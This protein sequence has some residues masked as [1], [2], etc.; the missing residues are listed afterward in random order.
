MEKTVK[1][2]SRPNGKKG[3]QEKRLP[4]RL[5]RDEDIPLLEARENLY[6]LAESLRQTL[7]TVRRI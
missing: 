5:R 4:S 3:Y 7:L 1:F 2:P 6:T